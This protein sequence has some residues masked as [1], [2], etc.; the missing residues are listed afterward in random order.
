MLWTQVITGLTIDEHD[1][2]QLLDAKGWNDR[3]NRLEE[4]G[5]PPNIIR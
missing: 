5:G 1:A 4:L 2:I 3:R